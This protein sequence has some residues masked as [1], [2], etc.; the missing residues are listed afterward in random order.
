MQGINTMGLF[1][2]IQED[3]GYERMDLVMTVVENICYDVMEYTRSQ[4]NDAVY[5]L[6]KL[7]SELPEDMLMKFLPKE[8]TPYMPEYCGEYRVEGSLTVAVSDFI[9]DTMVK[10]GEP[11]RPS[12][13]TPRSDDH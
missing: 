1:T 11:T 4:D 7:I 10:S 9:V 2:D 12:D 8:G 13:C 5:A 3:D 6:T